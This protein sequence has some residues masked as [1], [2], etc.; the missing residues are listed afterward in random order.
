MSGMKINN[1]NRIIKLGILSLTVAV[2]GSSCIKSVT[3]GTDFSSLKPTVLIP[4]GGMANFSSNALL[5][6]P[7]DASDTAHFFV[8]YAS[9]TTAPQDEVIPIGIDDAALA[10]YNALGGSQYAK[11]PDSIYSFTAT[12]ATVPK[13]ANYSSAVQLTMYPDKIDLTQNYML[14]ISI[15]TAPAGSTIASN[16][17]TIYYHLIGNPI[18]GPYNQEWI[19]YNNQAGTGVPAYDQTFGGLFA[20]IDGTTIN[21]TSGSAGLVYVLTF[22]NTAGVLS[23]FQVSFDPGSVAASG[24]TITGGPTVIL[25]D[26]IGGN[27]TFN[28][29]YNNS[30]GAARNITDKFTK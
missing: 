25:A 16:Y 15:K 30:A 23:N 9:T 10:A 22:T 13:G 28:F 18:A 27:Y 24:V 5:F 7:T 20:P 3:T 17:T 4:D 19:R 6:P 8:N 2:F 11:F 1:M 29:T 26:P 21:A 12:S 14:P